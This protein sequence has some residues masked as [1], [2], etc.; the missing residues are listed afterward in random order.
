MKKI[1]LTAAL[2]VAILAGAIP[3]MSGKPFEG[4]ITY[5]IAYPDS[6]MSESQMAMFPK[7]FTVSVKGT[8]ARTEMAVGGGSVVSIT[9]YTEKSTINLINMMGQKLAIKQSYEELQQEMAAEGQ[10]TVEH[11]T[12]TRVIAGYTCKKA[13]IKVNDDGAVSTYEVYY[14]SELGT[15]QVNF[16]KPWYKEIDGVML[17]F[18]L[19]N[20]DMNMKFTATAVDKKTLPAK[21]FEIPADY[22]LTTQEE[23]K[24][25][26][27][28]GGE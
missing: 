12:E 15:K 20:R 14:T 18:V 1:L 8:K 19:R 10:A 23:L 3:A 25:K 13:V 27:G 9:D 16:D 11:S 4:V 2:L 17:E 5:K 28:G 6:K 21:D 7:V 22:T 24:S 26:F